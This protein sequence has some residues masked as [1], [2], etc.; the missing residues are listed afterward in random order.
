MDS[1]SDGSN[2]IDNLAFKVDEHLQEIR[3][4]LC[5]VALVALGYAVKSIKPFTKFSQIQHIPPTFIEK[6]IKLNGRV[7]DI[8]VS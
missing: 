6:N 8:K 2:L 5:T 7:V 1:N 4:G 3:I